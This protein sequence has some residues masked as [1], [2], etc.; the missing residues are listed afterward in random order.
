MNH[1]F[2]LFNIINSKWKKKT[3]F[4]NAVIEFSNN[5]LKILVFNYVKDLI[6]TNSNFVQKKKIIYKLI[7]IQVYKKLKKKSHK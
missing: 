3:H 6:F 2:N 5:L 4:S 1:L 7:E